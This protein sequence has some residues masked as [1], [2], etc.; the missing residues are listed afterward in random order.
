ML[1]KT[2]S[3]QRQYQLLSAH[4]LEDKG[5]EDFIQHIFLF[6]IDSQFV[7][8]NTYMVSIEFIFLFLETSSGFKNNFSCFEEAHDEMRVLLREGNKP[9]IYVKERVGYADLSVNTSSNARKFQW[10][11]QDRENLILGT[12]R[13][14]VDNAAI[15]NNR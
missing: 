14:I 1:K 2:Q 6:L 11:E 8:T 15:W 10:D 3:C 7:E 4:Q 13:K 5:T 9:E 12:N